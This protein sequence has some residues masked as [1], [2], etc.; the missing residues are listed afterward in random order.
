MTIR[1]DG[2]A[3]IITGA[4]AGIG[5]ATAL[6][7]AERGARILVNDADIGRAEET[8]A[9]IRSNGGDGIG[10]GSPVGTTQAARQIVAAAVAA[11]GRVDI[12]VN[13]AGISRPA[14]FG[15]DSVWRLGRQLRTGNV[16]RNAV[17][18][19]RT[20]PYGGFKQ[21]GIGREGG[22][23]GLRSFQEQKTVYLS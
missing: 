22:L 4:G 9:A 8:A 7:M 17:I 2:Q 14:A 12:L 11:F 13:N 3:A 10:E 1:L 6:L 23:E 16:A 18:V 5:R 20:W 19:D 15:D 21:S